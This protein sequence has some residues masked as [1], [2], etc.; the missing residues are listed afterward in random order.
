MKIR[1]KEDFR[2]F[3]K[4]Q[5][6]N[7]DFEKYKII[8]LVG[9]N[10][11]GK[12][13]ITYSIQNICG[14]TKK[15]NYLNMGGFSDEFTKAVEITGYENFHIIDTLC[16]NRDNP[17]SLSCAADAETFIDSGGFAV[18]FASHGNKNSYIFSETLKNMTNKCPDDKENLLVI[19]EIDSGFDVKM[20]Y[21][22]GKFGL[23]N[24]ANNI[25]S[26]I[27]FISHNPIVLLLLDYILD[28]GFFDVETMQY[29]TPKEYIK[30]VTGG[31]EL[32]I[33]KFGRLI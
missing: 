18:R 1:F 23:Y 30:R 25:N 31:L 10:G 5:E 7:L 27:L 24:I 17:Q 3:K 22:L 28:V 12:S 29:T 9:S 15:P 13:T 8:C 20:Q 19:D 16:A 32:N 14:T 21:Y 11:C 6:I 26:R 33:N 4:G 2:K